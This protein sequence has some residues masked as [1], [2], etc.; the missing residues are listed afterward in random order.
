[1]SY[2]VIRPFK[3]LND[4]E[5]HQYEVGEQFP[6]EGYHPSESFLN[7]LLSGWNSAGSIFI[8][9]ADNVSEVV[10]KPKRKRSTKKEDVL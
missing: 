5:N 2:L 8:A 1:M 4:E 7:G 9:A 10:Q 3:D 6:R